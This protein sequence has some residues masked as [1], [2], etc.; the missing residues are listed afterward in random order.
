[1]SVASQVPNFF[2]FS[3]LYKSLA[4]DIGFKWRLDLERPLLGVKH[5]EKE[6][7][8]F[9]SILGEEALLLD[10]FLRDI[11][12]RNDAINPSRLE[13]NQTFI[14]PPSWCTTDDVTDKHI[15]RQTTTNV[16]SAG[17]ERIDRIE[18]CHSG[19]CNSIVF[20]SKTTYFL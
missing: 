5:D 20:S 17:T 10:G 19:L 3:T 18:K 1:M 13:I 4:R 12:S 11:D 7:Q 15:D 14:P 16:P 8:T 9:S 6:M 2:G